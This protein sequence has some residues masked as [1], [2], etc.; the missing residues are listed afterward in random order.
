[1]FADGIVPVVG[2]LRA[3]GQ[4]VLGRDESGVQLGGALQEILDLVEVFVEDTADNLGFGMVSIDND[5][6]VG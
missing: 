1:M 2:S 3:D 6:L 4:Q 5:R